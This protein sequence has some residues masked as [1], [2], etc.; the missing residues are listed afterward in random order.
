MQARCGKKNRA[1]IK[2][3]P[4]AQNQKSG[5]ILF[6]SSVLSVPYDLFVLF[7]SSSSALR[8]A[9]FAGGSASGGA[10]GLFLR[11]GRFG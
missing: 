8:L 5:K 3:A 11:R 4:T 2:P 6:I 1:G 9:L 10:A 7:F